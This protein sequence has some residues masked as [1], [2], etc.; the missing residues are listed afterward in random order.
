MYRIVH[1]IPVYDDRGGLS[2][3][4]YETIATAFT[5]KWAAVLRDREIEAMGVAYGEYGCEVRD[6]DFRLVPEA[7]YTRRPP[8]VYSA[9]ETVRFN[10]DEIPF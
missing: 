5:A 2:S 4:R 1:V 10:P 3:I 6:Q 9:V 8:V 7:F